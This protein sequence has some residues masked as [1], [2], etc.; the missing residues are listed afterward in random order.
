MP[1]MKPAYGG[2]ILLW[3]CSL[4][5]GPYGGATLRSCAPLQEES[6]EEVRDLRR[7]QPLT[8]LSS[9]SGSPLFLSLSPL[10]V[11]SESPYVSARSLSGGCSRIRPWV[12][13]IDGGDFPWKWRVLQTQIQCS[14]FK[15]RWVQF[16]NCVADWMFCWCLG[17]R[18]LIWFV[19]ARSVFAVDWHCSGGD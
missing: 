5:R 16:Q 13:R 10:L 2:N 1:A 14:P 18:I 3:Q 7:S 19:G 9:P 8:L 4:L 15:S 11:Q 6:Q 17:F 12:S